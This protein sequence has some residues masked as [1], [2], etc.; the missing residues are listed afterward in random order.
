MSVSHLQHTD[1]TAVARV[2]WIHVRSSA[3]G[4][5][6]P[7]SNSESVL[8]MST[9]C[10]GLFDESMS[11]LSITI[12][13]APFCIRQRLHQH[14]RTKI[15]AVQGDGGVQTRSR[16]ISAMGSLRV[17]VSRVLRQFGRESFRTAIASFRKS[18]GAETEHFWGCF[19]RCDGR[20]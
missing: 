8:M 5:S 12:W 14:P 20:R 7:F 4:L 11:K 1:N 10:S 17:R 9:S 2:V 13:S 6:S 3:R 18:S 16:S 15:R 19:V